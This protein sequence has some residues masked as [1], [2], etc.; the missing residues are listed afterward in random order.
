M[1]CKRRRL[2]RK[3]RIRWEYK[4]QKHAVKLL[5]TKRWCAVKR[6]SIDWRKKQGGNNQETDQE[7]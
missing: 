5:H 2:T 3:P 7:A 1:N 6:N 4:A